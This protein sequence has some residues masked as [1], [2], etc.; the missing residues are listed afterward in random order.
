MLPSS[1]TLEAIAAYM[2]NGIVPPDYDAVTDCVYDANNNMLTCQFRTGGVTGTVV[3]TLTCTYDV[4]S[5]LLT[6]VRS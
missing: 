2:S 5:N 3:S 1:K 6:A 4:N